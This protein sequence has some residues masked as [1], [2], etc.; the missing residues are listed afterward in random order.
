MNLL[1]TLQAAG[2]LASTPDEETLAALAAARHATEDSRRVS[3]GSLFVAVSGTRSDG[4][5]HAAQAAAAGAVLIIGERPRI[6]RLAGLPYLH[7]S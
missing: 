4:H 2:L 6:D 3:P 5:D 1:D 7:V